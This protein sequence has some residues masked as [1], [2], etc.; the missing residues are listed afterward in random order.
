LRVENDET[1][2][3]ARYGLIK[4]KKEEPSVMDASEEKV[5]TTLRQQ[6][7]PCFWV[8]KNSFAVYIFPRTDGVMGFGTC[9]C[10]FFK[11]K[12][13]KRNYLMVVFFNTSHIM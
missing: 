13:K 9:F 3:G 1:N 6:E 10:L 2:D 5:P 11:L 12:K 8:F 4:P 7:K